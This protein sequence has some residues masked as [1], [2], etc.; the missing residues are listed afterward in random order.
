MDYQATLG[1]EYHFG[2]RGFYDSVIVDMRGIFR[3]SLH[4]ATRRRQDVY[5]APYVSDSE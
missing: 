3:V 2:S 4:V 5:Y 1:V